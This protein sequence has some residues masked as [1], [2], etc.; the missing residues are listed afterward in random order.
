MRKRL[1]TVLLA[2]AMVMSL[3]ACGGSK[4]SEKTEY[5]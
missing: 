2:G 5:I 1:I 3:T 4:D